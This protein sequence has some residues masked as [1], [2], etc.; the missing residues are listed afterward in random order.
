MR[1][2]NLTPH[3]V[4]IVRDGKT[5]AE[6]PSA[7]VAR[8]QQSDMK[9]SELALESG[10]AVD[11]VRTTFGAPTDLPE[12]EAGTMY[13]VSLATAQSAKANGRQT[14]DLLLTSKPVRDAAGAVIGCEQFATL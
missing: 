9:V 2:I 8:A 1:I 4:T 5:M 12:P 10:V 13:I 6:F 14:G 11:V 3:N 7:G